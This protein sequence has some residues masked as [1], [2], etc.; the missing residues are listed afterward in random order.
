MKNLTASQFIVPVQEFN[1]SDNNKIL[2]GFIDSP[3]E[4]VKPCLVFGYTEDDVKE[5]MNFIVTACN[6]HNELIE[7]L[8][9]VGNIDGIEDTNRDLFLKI[10]TLLS[11][12]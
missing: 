6:L 10:V 11:K 1:A 3:L 12:I 9:D 8:Q 2:A 5:R 4:D 7:A